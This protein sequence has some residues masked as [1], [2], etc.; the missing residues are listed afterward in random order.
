M[1][2]FPNFLRS[3]PLTV[4]HEFQKAIQRGN[5]DKVKDLLTANPDLINTRLPNGSMPLSFAMRRGHANLVDTWMAK[6]NIW[7]TDDQKL[8]VLDHAFLTDKSLAEKL[9]KQ[10]PLTKNNTSN[11]GQLHRAIGNDDLS[12]L[13]DLLAKGLDPN[14]QDE[15]GITP[16]QIA[17]KKQNTEAI[18]SLLANGAN[19]FLERDNQLCAF[20]L[21]SKACLQKD[22]LKISTAEGLQFL[23]T[24]SYWILHFC[25][26]E[27]S[28]DYF[29]YLPSALVGLSTLAFY[30]DQFSSQSL[31][32]NL[33]ISGMMMALEQVPELKTPLQ[34]VRLGF[35]AKN[36]LAGLTAAVKNYKYNEARSL[37]RA[38]VS[39]VNVSEPLYSLVSKCANYTQSFFAKES[40]PKI[41]QNNDQTP[42]STHS[43]PKTPPQRPVFGVK[44]QTFE[45][46]GGSEKTPQTAKASHQVPTS[47]QA[48][49]PLPQNVQSDLLDNDKKR[50]V[51]LARHVDLEKCFD[52]A[53][54]WCIE[55]ELNQFSD[56]E[57][58]LLREIFW[59]IDRASI[60]DLLFL[61][62]MATVK[63]ANLRQDPHFEP[64]YEDLWGKLSRAARANTHPDKVRNDK[65]FIKVAE[66][67]HR[68]DTPSYARQWPP[69]RNF[70][71][72]IY[73][74]MFSNFFNKGNFEKHFTETE[75]ADDSFESKLDA[76]K[77]QLKE[78]LSITK[79]TFFNPVEKTFSHVDYLLFCYYEAKI[80]SSLGLSRFLSYSTAG[81]TTVM[82]LSKIEKI[83]E[84]ANLPNI[85]ETILP[86]NPTRTLAYIPVCLVNA[87]CLL[88][89][90]SIGKLNA[91]LVS[92]LATEWEMKIASSIIDTKYKS[93]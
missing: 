34:A 77:Q 11:S 40:V 8:S 2:T 59:K 12:L 55:K 89:A 26:D 76:F 52:D 49:L 70:H 83:W 48:R 28:A 27:Q 3:T 19:P 32:S 42:H 1:V 25:R 91:L 65:D 44:Q 38:T 7:E 47:P 74:D 21:L 41:P 68:V 36:A 80:L 50:F 84:K 86:E 13:K 15:R 57:R 82:Q 54:T 88:R 85:W 24:A 23:A 45:N 78:A 51:F 53:T 31:S 33:L 22:P 43:T 18:N 66:I 29:N 92:W 56:E 73:K 87:L 6:A 58:T 81:L 72:D 39:L 60:P 4:G 17:I 64:N 93:H 10:L 71:D 67:L 63:K 90:T 79:D 37:C 30:F 62:K 35:L 5:A 16:L 9:L 20:D 46:V 61:Y 69:Q 14:E 75:P